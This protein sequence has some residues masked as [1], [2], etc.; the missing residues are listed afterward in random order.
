[1]RPPALATDE[2]PTELALLHVV[3]TLKATEGYAPDVVVTLEP[4]SPLRSDGLIDRCVDTLQQ[5]GADSLVTVVE[6]R[7]CLGRV[8]GA[9]RFAY[10]F[11]N[12]PRRRQERAPL[13]KESGAVYATRTATLLGEHRIVGG[14]LCAVIVEAEEATDLNTPLDFI[15]AE[16]IVQWKQGGAA[17]HDSTCSHR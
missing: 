14:R 9:G 4:T 16:A 5:T 13:Y 6:T 12:Q 10:L 15:I 2:A 11:P 3:E 1:M 8:D 17:R 7:E